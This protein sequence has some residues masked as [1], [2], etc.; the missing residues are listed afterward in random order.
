MSTYTPPTISAPCFYVPGPLQLWV[1]TGVAHAM[2]F[3]GFSRGGVRIHEQVYWDEL[4]SDASGGERGP[5]A[6]F[7]LLGETH[8]IEAELAQYDKAI[9]AKL[10]KR[11]PVGVTRTKGMLMKCSGSN[12]RL[13][14]ISNEFQ[15]NYPNVYIIDPIEMPGVGFNTLYPRISF[16]CLEIASSGV[17][18]NTA[19]TVA[20]DGIATAS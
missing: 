8:S 18:W 17:P 9:V 1:D 12:F 7:Q 5:V 6:D 10:A 13:V 19:V 14:L 15:R 11:V 20:D 16:T 4:K 3:L 2:E